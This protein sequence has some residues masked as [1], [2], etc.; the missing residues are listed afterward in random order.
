MTGLDFVYQLGGLAL[1]RDQVEP[2][3]RHHQRTRKPENPIGNRVAM[4]VIVEE[5]SVDIAFAQGRLN[6]WE[7]HLNPLL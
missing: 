4:V 5:P 1:C 3:A 7:I 6:G 2:A